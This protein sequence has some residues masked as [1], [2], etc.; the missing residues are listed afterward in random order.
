MK[1][2]GK[3]DYKTGKAIIKPSCIIDYNENMGAVD[4]T[5]MLLSSVESVR[6]T[7]KWYKKLFFHI[8][9]LAVLNSYQLYKTRTTDYVPIEQYKTKLIKGLIKKYHTPL[10]RSG[11]GRR[12][13]AAD[14]DLRLTERHFFKFV[15]STKTKKTAMKRCVVCAKHGKR[16]ESRYMCSTCDVGLCVI[17]CFE[18]YHTRKIY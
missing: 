16:A 7:V 4:K 1:N 2:T 14:T 9:D 6:K 10:Q 12:S 17:P 18:V 5:D 15:P 11:G 13:D 3:K 8:L